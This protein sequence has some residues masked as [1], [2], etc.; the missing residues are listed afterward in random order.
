M[1]KPFDPEVEAERL[2]RA[3]QDDVRKDPHWRDLTS[4][5]ARE[6]FMEG[7]TRRAVAAALR[8]AYASGLDAALG[9][10][11]YADC[12]VCVR[13]RLSAEKARSKR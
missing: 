10:C 4:M 12:D 7:A 3:L 6:R 5:A 9:A 1:T 2:V 13:V 11:P 8:E